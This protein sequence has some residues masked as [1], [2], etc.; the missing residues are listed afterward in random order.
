LRGEGGGESPCRDEG[1]GPWKGARK[2]GETLLGKSG[3]SAWGG[4]RG[5][6]R[7]VRGGWEESNEWFRE[8]KEIG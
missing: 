2:G 7:L 6:G 1:N 5:G 8:G 3:A 4:K